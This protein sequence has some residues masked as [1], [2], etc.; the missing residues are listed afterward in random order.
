MVYSLDKKR[1]QL[2]TTIPLARIHGVNDLRL[3][4]VDYPNCGPDDLIVQVQQ[5]G[6]CGS[7]L[8]FLS[9]GGVMGPGEPLAI[10]HEF[11][12]LVHET[13][14]NV[15]HLKI[16]EKVVVHPLSNNNLIG[17]GGPEGGFSPYILVRNAANDHS[18]TLTMPASLPEFYGALVE[19]LSVAK[20][21]A[22]RVSVG[23]HDKVV[24]FGAGTIGL[25]LVLILKHLNL[26]DIVVVDLSAQR[27][28]IAASLGVHTL[29]GDDPELAQKLTDI[30]GSSSF[31]GMPMP[32][33]SVYFEMTGAKAA[34]E[35]ILEIA[36]PQSRVCLTGVHKQP[37]SIDLAMLMAKEVSIIPAMAY[38]G[39]FEEVLELLR[40]GSIDPGVLVTHHFPLSDIENAFIAAQD[41]Q[42]AVKVLVDCQR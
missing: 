7:D 21:S 19:P 25:S 42:S 6:I 30:H 4:T 12:G 39:E 10:G 24:I 18:C 33:S 23:A 20:H 27:L 13:G 11:W 32:G 15:T 34:F 16:G 9:L 5:C 1:P 8:G 14:G 29:R 35:N 31:F 3:D 2:M 17:N 37:V 36:G 41:T 26:Q 22:N 38:E 40:E 28:D